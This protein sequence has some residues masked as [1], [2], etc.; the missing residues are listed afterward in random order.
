MSSGAGSIRLLLSL[1]EELRAAGVS[2]RR[3]EEAASTLFPPLRD[4]YKG[5]AA[6]YR[7]FDEEMQRLGLED[8]TT[9]YR[10]AI[11]RL[12]AGVSDDEPLPSVLHGI[13][14]VCVSQMYDLTWFQ[15]EMLRALARVVGVKV[16][17]PWESSRPEV[18]GYVST[19]LARLESLGG[20]N[21]RLDLEFDDLG[22]DDALS[23]LRR[24][25][26]STSPVTEDTE[27][28]PRVITA[29]GH[30]PQ[31][32][33]IG[34]E[35]RRLL[36]EGTPASDMAVA[37]RDLS[38]YGP[39]MEDVFR[40]YR[41]P[42]SLRRGM[43][44][45]MSPLVKSA[46]AVFE[47]IESRFER[48]E[49]L[50]L[51]KSAYFEPF[52][53]KPGGA[54]FAPEEVEGHIL[55][56]GVIDDREGGGWEQRLR[57]YAAREGSPDIVALREGAS[58]CLVRLKTLGKPMSVPDFCNAFRRFLMNAGLY[59]M[60]L[61]PSETFERDARALALLEETLTDMAETYRRIEGREVMTPAAFY[62]LLLSA[63]EGKSIESPSEEGVAVLSFHD[64]RGLRAPYLFLGGL[65]EG[66]V[67]APP[68]PDPLMPDAQRQALNSA[69]K[70]KVFR[71]RA[72]RA[73][74]EPLLF[75]MALA[76]GERITLSWSCT[77]ISGRETL[78]SFYLRELGVANAR[79]DPAAGFPPLA[80]AMEPQEVETA[81]FRNLFG[82][83]RVDEEGLSNAI[84]LVL[85]GRLSSMDTLM[86]TV[87][88]ETLRQVV[89]SGGM[90]TAGPFSGLLSDDEI[91][92]VIRER[93]FPDGR[94]EA[95]PWSPTALERY[96]AC[97]F[98]FFA[99]RVLG[100]LAEE[101]PSIEVER[102]EEGS[103]VHA[104]LREGF[105]RLRDRG[106]LPLSGREEEREVFFGAV[107]QVIRRWEEE[108]PLGNPVLW[109]ARKDE[110][111]TVLGWMFN[112]EPALEQ[113]GFVPSHFEVAFGD[114]NCPMTLCGL[115]GEQ[116]ALKGRIDR[117]DMKEGGL[118]VV[119]YKHSSDDK[120]KNFSKPE[121][122]GVSSFQLPVYLMAAKR[123][124]PEHAAQMEALIYLLKKYDKPYQSSGNAD[125]LLTEDT[126]RR[127]TM[128][129]EGSP[130]FIDR[131]V[132]LVERMRSGD[133]SVYPADCPDYCDYRG[134]CRYEKRGKGGDNA[135]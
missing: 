108:R 124:F 63:M 33:A 47:I 66:E 41:I 94:P 90:V 134:V 69:L 68:S 98:A 104:A 5:I 131:T 43:P 19:T 61:A 21:L 125:E 59:R 62:R 58:A 107:M 129:A 96:A 101:K 13:R 89:E 100:I 29:R 130:A 48:E 34:R 51:L 116:V 97:P 133:F 117:V 122:W 57:A 105:L 80:D 50:R 77:D 46:L 92:R 1:I 15:V 23:P 42:L 54:P 82:R 120:K 37:F 64:M 26:L 106:Y 87:R 118:R 72:E 7:L 111:L 113:G 85:P 40:R 38:V 24:R 119:D 103:L 22:S 70:K 110:L 52:L 36:D 75:A 31:C 3:F 65:N 76:A 35:V 99:E 93:V 44:L 17:I 11:A 79:K 88:R 121:T 18:F 2:P 10:R 14:E 73:Q 49:M 67:P 115:Q 128:A 86:A 20:E 45:A 28:T 84:T 127:R 4:K 60:A 27:N 12:S 6:L 112:H 109:Q 132:A 123:L 9:L 81:L 53:N 95:Q 78:P 39:M 25:F 114:E 126:E 55:K 56:A 135:E 16:T 102:S 30:Y 8:Q 91:R 32:E 74:A 71:S 83:S